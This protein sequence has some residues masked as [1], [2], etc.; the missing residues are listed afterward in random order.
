MFSEFMSELFQLYE[1]TVMYLASAQNTELYMV[2]E[3]PYH[4]LVLPLAWF[5]TKRHDILYRVNIHKQL[6]QLNG[7][8]RRDDIKAINIQNKHTS[9]L[10]NKYVSCKQYQMACYVLG[11]GIHHAAQNLLL[12][13]N[14]IL[15]HGG[16]SRLLQNVGMYLSN[17]VVSLPTNQAN[18]FK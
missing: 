9:I 16:D 4:T 5:I 17:C 6:L 3:H 13:W 15:T 11:C 18:W 12:L 14:T 10:T 2:T 8:V 1:C 7:T